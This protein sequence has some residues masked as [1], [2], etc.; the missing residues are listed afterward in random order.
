MYGFFFSEV[1][2][3]F[4]QMYELQTHDNPNKIFIQRVSGKRIK[5][6]INYRVLG[7]IESL[8]L[9]RIRLSRT[10]ERLRD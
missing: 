4:F 2:I 5:I 7:K 8:L 6:I 1:N 10:F 3:P 9:C